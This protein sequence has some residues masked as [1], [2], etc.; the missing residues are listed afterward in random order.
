MD[1]PMRGRDTGP[2][3]EKEENSES[4][5]E[6]NRRIFVRKTERGSK[7]VG[8]KLLHGQKDRVDQH[9]TVADLRR[10]VAFA[11]VDVP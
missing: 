6:T 2:V 8:H 5:E 1:E 11:F 9:V 10:L 3:Q 4:K 7:R